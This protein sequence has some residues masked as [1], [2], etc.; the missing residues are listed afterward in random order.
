MSSNTQYM[1]RDEILT[2]HVGMEFTYQA[3]VDQLLRGCS[4]QA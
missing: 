1:N 4:F 3:L 2:M